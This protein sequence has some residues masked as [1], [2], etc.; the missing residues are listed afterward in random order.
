MMSSFLNDSI[1]QNFLN[2]VNIE[3]ISR[4]E[5]YLLSTIYSHIIISLLYNSNSLSSLKTNVKNIIHTNKNFSVTKPCSNQYKLLKIKVNN[6]LSK[7]SLLDC[8]SFC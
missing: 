4:D 6:S 8:E 2:E 7:C 3:N 5:F 1:I